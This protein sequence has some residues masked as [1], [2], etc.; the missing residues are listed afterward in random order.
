MSAAEIPQKYLSKLLTALSAKDS[1]Y[2]CTFK[3]CDHIFKQLAGIYNHLCCLHLGVSVGCYYCS[4]C[5]WTSKGWSDHHAGK[6]PLLNPYPSGA[7]LEQLLIKKAQAATT[8]N[9]EA[10]LL[11]PA[12]KGSAI[13]DALSTNSTEEGDD[14]PAGNEEDD[15]PPILLPLENPSLFLPGELQLPMSAVTM[16]IP[17]VEGF[18]GAHPHVPVTS[19]GSGCCKKAMPHRS[20]HT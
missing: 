11:S 10:S 13:V 15:V 16:A 5:W 9:S 19:I 20:T 3:G 1:L 12:D 2:T 8:I 6:H 18:R 14:D 7:D 17:S 4:G